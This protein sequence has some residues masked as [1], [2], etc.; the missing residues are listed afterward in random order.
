M[1]TSAL[2]RSVV[3]IK[4]ERIVIL[5]EAMLMSNEGRRCVLFF[6]PHCSLFISGGF[7]ASLE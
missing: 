7:L 4:I 2:F 1:K 3:K 6:I 5:N